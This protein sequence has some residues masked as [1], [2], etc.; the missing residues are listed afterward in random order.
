MATFSEQVDGFRRA[1]LA[2]TLAS[3]GGNVSQA[4]RALGLQRTSVWRLIRKYRLSELRRG[5]QAPN[6]RGG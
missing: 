3:T 5:P 6:T 1:V 4:A 2:H